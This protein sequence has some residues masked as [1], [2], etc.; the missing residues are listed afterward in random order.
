MATH[1]KRPLNSCQLTGR[2]AGVWLQPAV[3]SACTLV[4]GIVCAPARAWALDVPLLMFDVNVFLL[5]LG[6]LLLLIYPV[7]KF[8]LQPLAGVLQ[9]REEATAGAQERASELI[10]AA[11]QAREELEAKLS[12]A[13]SEGQAKRA[14]IL[15]DAEEAARGVVAAARD[16]ANQEMDGVRSGIADE[17]RAARETLRTDSQAL[18]REAAARILGRELAS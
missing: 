13:R 1:P 18:A 11:A 6:V 7:N 2:T 8:L 15:A 10:S 16:A 17:L 3:V 12:D 14:A 9:A 5:N 4:L